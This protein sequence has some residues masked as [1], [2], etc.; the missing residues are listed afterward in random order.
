VKTPAWVYAASLGVGVTGVFVPVFAPELVGPWRGSRAAFAVAAGV[1]VAAHEL[2]HHVFRSKALPGALVGAAALAVLALVSLPI[3]WCAF[4]ANLAVSGPDVW[5]A[6]AG[7]G[8]TAGS[9]GS[10]RRP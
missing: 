9:P 8:P 7:A 5:E 3:G 2:L 1:S 4:L 6:L 10:D